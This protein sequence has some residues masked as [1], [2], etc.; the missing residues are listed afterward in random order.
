MAQEDIETAQFTLNPLYIQAARDEADARR[1]AEA[2]GQE[3][4]PGHL[5]YARDEKEVLGN[6]AGTSPLRAKAAESDAAEPSARAD[7]PALGR[8]R[9]DDESA[10]DRDEQTGPKGKSWAALAAKQ[11]QIARVRQEVDKLLMIRENAYSADLTAYKARL[12]ELRF[13]RV[14]V[15]MALVSGSDEYDDGDLLA[16]DRQIAQLVKITGRR[17][18]DAAPQGFVAELEAK[19]N[20]LKSELE[21]LNAE[22][23]ELAADHGLAIAVKKAKDYIEALKLASNLRH[24]LLALAALVPGDGPLMNLNLGGELPIPSGLEVFASIRSEDLAITL[25][26]VEAAKAR[27]RAEWAF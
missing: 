25:E 3:S 5:E 2:M 7:R 12:N 9:T 23:K 19:I 1:K 26:G 11:T 4:S 17:K 10:G 15:Q 8:A 22:L 24:E 6:Q 13:K 16:L 18:P 21:I 27:I 14:A 20:G